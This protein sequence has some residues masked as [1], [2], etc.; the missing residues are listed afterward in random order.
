MGGE[1]SRNYVNHQHDSDHRRYEDK[2][3]G[4][5]PSLLTKLLTSASPTPEISPL[6]HEL[7]QVAAPVSDI[8]LKAQREASKGKQV[9]SGVMLVVWFAPFLHVSRVDMRAPL[10]RKAAAP[11]WQAL[12]MDHWHRL[13]M[14]RQHVPHGALHC[15]SSRCCNLESR[16]G[17]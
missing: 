4:G 17:V 11:T 12:L 9:R 15:P 3:S 14:W 10:G 7:A 2:L 8:T 5:G 16:G 1:A 13:C 6:H